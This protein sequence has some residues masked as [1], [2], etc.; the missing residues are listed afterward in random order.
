M[1]CLTVM[2]SRC[3]GC[4]MCEAPQMPALPLFLKPV[5]VLYLREIHE[6]GRVQCRC[7]DSELGFTP[8]SHVERLS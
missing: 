5:D 7:R 6:L 8:S 2:P 4:F 1:S 3:P